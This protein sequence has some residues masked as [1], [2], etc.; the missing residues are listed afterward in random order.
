MKAACCIEPGRLEIVQRPDPTPSGDDDVVLRIR[1]VGVCGTDIHIVGGKH[2]YLEYPRVLGH[3]LSGEVVEAPRS[4]AVKPG[5]LVYVNPYIACGT[6]I[7]CRKGR[8]NCCTR[9]G[10]LGVH[11]DGGMAEFLA[12]PARNV[13]RAEGIGEEAAAAVEFLAIGAHAVARSEL[14]AGD[15]V[16]VIGAGPIGLGVMLFAGLRGAQVTALDVNAGR[17]AF[18]RDALG[19]PHTVVAGEGAAGELAALTGGEMFDVVFD[20]TGNPK[21]ME[22]AFGHVAHTG[23]LVLVG[24]VRTDLTFSDPEFHKREMR[25]IASRNAL[26]SDFATVLDAMREGHVPLDRLITHRCALDAVPGQMPVWT[27]PA[28]GTIK[29]MV[30]L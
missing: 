30:T 6:C 18:C 5:D 3:E 7:A 16:L 17:L 14:S 12:L 25:L 26:A 9:I 20:A 1:R 24:I 21:S 13:F 11:R 22:A 8:P 28:S 2:P 15:R 4:A 27:D 19:V 23:T 29:A 10:V